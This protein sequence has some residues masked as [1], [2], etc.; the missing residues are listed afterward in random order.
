[1][2]IMQDVFEEIRDIIETPPQ[3]YIPPPEFSALVTDVQH[4]YLQLTIVS[5]FPR[6]T[7]SERHVDIIV[8]IS[9]APDVAF[10]LERAARMLQDAAAGR[11][12]GIADFARER[13]QWGL[14][15]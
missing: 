6:A 7:R 8:R 3:A 11:T 5:T 10:Q 1:M 14:A 4:G 13:A 9:E 2:S 12:R 15:Q